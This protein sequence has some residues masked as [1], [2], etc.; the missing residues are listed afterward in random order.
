[1]TGQKRTN[2]FRKFKDD[3]GQSTTYLGLATHHK[4][5]YNYHENEVRAPHVQ[6]DK[7]DYGGRDSQTKQP[8]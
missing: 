6:R 3:L 4:T 1:M 5:H 7:L 2:S 8:L